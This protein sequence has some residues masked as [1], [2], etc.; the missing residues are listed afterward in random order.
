VGH[1]DAADQFRAARHG[2]LLADRSDLGLALFSGKD[3]ADLLHRLTTAAVKGLQPGQ[4]TAAVFATPKGRILDLV[5][6]HRLPE[7]I[8]AITAPRR[9]A[10]VI[11]WVER[12]TF[13]DTVQAEDRGAS[14]A[15][16]G[17]Y[18]AGAAATIARAFGDAAA[19]I[20][21]HH[22]VVVDCAGSP[23]TLVRS[24]PLG[25]DG[26]LLVAPSAAIGAA[27]AVLRQ[28]D[29][30]LVDAGP[31]ALEVLRVEAGLPAPGSELTGE[32]NPWEA[33]L[34]E[35]IAFNK[36]C[37]VGQEVIARLHTYRKVARL[38]VRIELEGTI[39]PA[40][41][42]AIVRDTDRIGAITS[43]VAVPGEDRVVAIGYVRDEEAGAAGPVG[44]ETPAGSRPGRLR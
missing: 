13:R 36:G 38:L 39:V 27:R 35:A 30:G 9:A 3:A 2:A 20:Q 43:A 15:A 10:E 7:G 4:G 34:D 37:Y 16:L 25:G 40:P 44:V 12:Y 33:R 5:T 17:L 26:W 11:A 31:Q 14:H 29:A 24:W 28:A 22:A 1:D 6:L 19:G 41:G 21:R 42:A 18:G 23:A 8:L 32:H